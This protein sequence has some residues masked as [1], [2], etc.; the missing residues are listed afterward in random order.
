MLEYLRNAADKPLAKVLMF[1]LIFSFVG[2]G[3]AE[4]IFGGAVRDTTLVR[5]GNAEISV[6]QFNSLLFDK[7]K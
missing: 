7:D 5:V 4:W 1:V 2:W 6:Q 3:A